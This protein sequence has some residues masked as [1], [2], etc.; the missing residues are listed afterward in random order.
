MKIVQVITRMDTIG[1]AQVHVRDLS[2]RL[3]AE[4]SEVSIITGERLDSSLEIDQ[5]IT[6]FQSLSLKRAVHPY[7]DVRAIFEVRQLLKKTQPD[8]VATHSS[9]AGLIGR[10]AARSLGIP[11]VFTAHGWAFT[12]GISSEKR[13][14]YITIEKVLGKITD[15]V[16]TVSNYDRQLAISNSVLPSHKIKTVH[17][18]VLPLKKTLPTENVAK[19]FIN[20]LMVARFDVPKKQMDL[21]QACEKIENL[22]WQLSFVGEGTHLTEAKQ[23]VQ[24][25]HL[26][27]RVRF[28]GAMKSIESTLSDSQIFVLL[29]DYEGLPLS[30]LEAMQAG[31]PIIASDVGGVKEAVIDEENG[32]LIPKQNQGILIERLTELLTDASLREEMG[33]RSKELFH[34]QFTFEKMYVQTKS[35]YQNVVDIKR[36]KEKDC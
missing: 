4:G 29:S 19:A 5:K 23:Y 17:N 35:V 10:I 9:K 27:E 31:L 20:I 28:Y 12:E 7:Y 30:I 21:I 36:K 18:G 34:E 26:Q 6:Y 13:K 1:G 11:T 25:H 33:K 8:L 24:I 2:N 14:V 32:F 22:P 3:V 16:I 15:R